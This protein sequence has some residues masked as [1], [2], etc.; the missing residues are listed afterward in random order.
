[1]GYIKLLEIKSII[2]LVVILFIFTNETVINN[3]VLIKSLNNPILISSN[4]GVTIYSYGS[5]IW[6]NITSRINLYENNFCY[7]HT[8][9]TLIK[10]DDPNNPY[11]LYSL[12]SDYFISLTTSNC[13]AKMVPRFEFPSSTSFIS[14][15]QENNFETSEF[16]EKNET[17]IVTGWRCRIPDNEIIIY[18]KFDSFALIFNY[19]ERNETIKI[20]T[21]QL[22]DIMSCKK[23]DSSLYLCAL[24]CGNRLYIYSYAYQTK[25]PENINDCEMKLVFD[26]AISFMNSHTQ[27]R[28]FDTSSEETKL[29]CAKNTMSYEMQCF[30]LTYEYNEFEII[31]DFD[32]ETNI[33]TV[34]NN[35]NISLTYE[36]I[37]FSFPLEENNNEHCIFKESVE[38]EYLF[39]CGGLNLIKCARI[40]SGFSYIDSFELN[41]EGTNTHLDF[42]VN[43]NII[44]IYYLN[45][46]S[47][48]YTYVRYYDYYIILPS[49]PNNSY[50]II[51]QSS[52]SD[53]LRKLIE[54][55]MATDYYIEFIQLPSD[56]GNLTVDNDTIDSNY[57][58]KIL[59]E[60]T[61]SQYF[62]FISL[63]D[64]SIKNFKIIYLISL[65]ETFSNECDI[66]LDILECYESCR[67]C[68]KSA[69]YSDEN[70]HNCEPESC[71]EGFYLDP[72][73][74][75]NCWRDN[76]GK[77]NWYLDYD[78][79]KF[80]LCND[81]CAECDGPLDSNCLS[82]KS[83]TDLKY[84]YNKKCYTKCPDGF[85]PDK[86]KDYYIC[87][88]C[89][90]TCATC[91]KNGINDNNMNCDSCK[92]NSIF[93][94][95]LC[96]IEYSSE[97]KTFFIPGTNTI[98]SCYQKFNFFIKENTY[99]CVSSIPAEGFYLSNARTGLFS[100]CDPA[101]RTC[102]GKSSETNSN[103]ILCFDE[104]LNFFQGNCIERCYDGYYS[105]EKSETNIQKKCVAC[106]TKCSKCEKGEEFNS[107]YK[108]VKMNCLECKKDKDPLDPNNLIQNNIYLDGNCL[109]IVEYSEEKIT[110]DISSINLGSNNIKS[111]LDYNLSIFNGE[112]ECITKPINTYYILDNEENTGVIKYCHEACASCNGAPDNDLQNTNCIECS[113]GYYKTEDS[114][115]NCILESQIPNNYYKN[116]DDN[117]Y[118]K[119]YTRCQTCLRT[120]D[121]KAN[122][123]NMGCESCIDNYYFLYQTNNCYNDSFLDENIDYYLNSDD[124][125]FHK[126][127]PSCKRCTTGKVDENHNCEE[128]KDNFYFEENTNNCYDSSY[129]EQG[130]Y[131][132]T[133]TIDLESELPIFKKCYSKCK[134][135]DNYMI[136]ENM[137]CLTCINEYYKIKDTKNCITDITNN[138]YYLKDNIAIPCEENCLT[139]SDGPS[140]INENNIDNNNNTITTITNNCLS[141][142][143]GKNLYLV[144][145]LNN[146][147][148][149]DFLNHGFYLE[150]ELDGTKIIHKCYQSCSLCDKGKEIDS[151]TNKEIHNCNQCIDNYYRLLDDEY[152]NNCYGD[153]M[154]E[155]GY[156]LARNFWQ[157][158]HENCGSCSGKT[159]YDET[160]NIVSQNCLT[161]Y[162]GFY[163]IYQTSN[164]IDESY[165]EKGYYFDDSEEVYKECDIS[166]KSC[167]KYSTEDDPK[168]LSCNNEKGYFSAE[169]KP[170][171]ICYNRTN[172]GSEYVLA[173]RYDENG[174]KY[175]KWSLCYETCYLCSKYGNEEEHGCTSCISK[176]YLIYGSSNCVT[177]DYALNNGYYFNTTFSQY[178][179]CDDS[180]NNCYGGPIDENTNCKECNYNE[181]YYPI[182][183]KSN[184]YCYNNETI[185]EGYFLNQ[186]SQPYKW[187]SCYDNCATCEYKG[188]KNK[189]NCLSCK[190]TLKNKY[191]KNIYFLLM[192]G[193]CIE[194]CPDNL[195]LTKDGDC[196]SNCPSGTY[197]YQLNYN[198]SCVEYCP[199]KYVISSDGKKCELPEF[200][201]YINPDE[202]K[203][204]ISNDIASYV[205]SSKIIDLDNLQAYIT[206]SNTLNQE[207]QTSNKISSIS[208][209][210]NFLVA[211]KKKNNIPD[212]ENLIIA[213]IETK[214]TS[215]SNNNLK[216]NNNDLISLGK[217]VQ[218]IIYDKTGKQLDLSNCNDEQITVM[219]YIADLPYIN[220]EEAKDFYQKGVDVFNESDPFFN[221][222]CYPFTTN[223]SSDI[224]LADRRTDIFR[225]ISF[226]DSGCI[227][228][229]IDYDLMIVNCLCTIDSINNDNDNEQNGIILNNNKNK[230][231]SELYDTNIILMKCSN[232]VFNSEIL[233][234]NIGFYL[235]ISMYVFEIISFGIFIKNGLTPIKNFMLIF[236]AGSG[237]AAHP[238]KLKHLLSLNEKNNENNKEDEIQKTIL[239]NQLLNK[240]KKKI[241]KIRNK[242]NEIDD[243][244][245]VKY[246]ESD[247]DG[248]ESNRKSLNNIDNNNKNKKIIND[249]DE[250][251]SKSDISDTDSE[252][253]KKTR[254]TKRGHSNKKKTNQR[255]NLVYSKENIKEKPEYIKELQNQD[256]PIDIL[257][258]ITSHKKN[259]KN[260]NSQA[261]KN[262]Y[263]TKNESENYSINSESDQQVKS[264]KEKKHSNKKEENE[265]KSYI[266]KKSKI[267]NKEKEQ[268]EKEKEKEQETIIPYKNKN[269]KIVTNIG[270]PKYNKEKNNYSFTSEEFSIMTYEE[271]IKNDKRLL[272]NIYCGY[273]SENNFIFNTFISD[274]F[275]DLRSLKINLFCF[276]LELIFVL[277]ALFYTDTYIS[278]TYKNNGDFAL[279]TSLPKVFYSFLV[280][281]FVNIFLKLLSSDKKEIFRAIKEKDDKI[282]YNDLVDIVLAKFKIKLIIFFV[283][284]FIFSFIFL[285]YVSAFC[286]VYQNTKLLWLYGCLE[287]IAVDIIFTFIYCILIA[288]FRFYG[289]KKRIKC[290]Y[291]FANFLNI[292]F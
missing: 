46:I 212:D 20:S 32:E 149:L 70:N 229:G 273:L 65:K 116:L 144:E 22:E 23:M 268:K 43:S 82:C 24:I 66:N 215:E 119:C 136:D 45:S 204:I 134:T 198:Y 279:F 127:Y 200:Q 179:K 64:K 34:T 95:K 106:Y 97:N 242:K 266:S 237:T 159:T 54:R 151:T 126:C 287:T 180:C 187:S 63:N 81:L 19:I 207:F 241:T 160:N 118:Y 132:D 124:N 167:E 138:G 58:E 125:Q 30:E 148:T 142:D 248:Y 194:S 174:N 21:C 203:S 153:E 197:H 121:Q 265:K 246:S 258:N 85:Y 249:E 117:I 147:E 257:D 146:C 170:T 96:F 84:L 202:F 292:L 72:E 69:E 131:L 288:S 195:F 253:E 33:T 88:S 68:S 48:V 274:S 206:Y 177:N 13:T 47:N 267:K 284:Q 115:T 60:D 133:F 61:N 259:E 220:L 129:T 264:K 244:L 102:N 251:V 39:C 238:P 218:I 41:I 27:V 122:L 103:C 154:L 209:I 277:N 233:K 193:N 29:I 290:Y 281:I 184:K 243:A 240:N 211:V 280:S 79:N 219:K 87:K 36:D 166:C 59:V 93:L 3:P 161:C 196:V 15:I 247:Y 16:Y 11:Y 7:Y 10:T 162:T 282:E 231:A 208:N 17:K 4:T 156:R 135:C 94:Y 101:C 189:M 252:K 199:E 163:F 250:K 190:T 80:F 256:H 62:E 9:N 289:I 6:R 67:L 276:R 55:E 28:M 113:E 214:Q 141:C 111:C 157:I 168:C 112:F 53:D 269:K 228:N 31:E 52:F 227:Y 173:D 120:L 35:Y 272:S 49:C 158:C 104:N 114:E 155:E 263:I 50:S 261:N 37:L 216:G 186:F 130:F 76:E 271:A 262:K 14:Y 18:G 107:Q 191:N 99:E 176:H 185:G 171:S 25:D 239:I 230:F 57:T 74:N 137:N 145:D 12:N 254:I 234:S 236:Q 275:V 98:S 181:N 109:P 5:K 83:D 152:E 225:N 91:S 178:V 92:E 201:A 255:N 71:K 278:S 40:S 86:K 165:L 1:M 182:E 285:Y 192:N 221:D 108:L 217:D 205:N 89:Y 150:E 260:K 286:A 100:P 226:C 172:I 128:C 283:F 169:N 175:K 75:T 143:E 78:Q 232:L 270:K 245:V 105:L 123:D 223:F 8:I 26:E 56:Y 224:I 110:F 73:V 188:T 44:I 235:T 140:P 183:D 2:F 213:I 77:S 38:N 291:Y 42:I 90:E 51:P 210:D 222:I 164:C 139:C